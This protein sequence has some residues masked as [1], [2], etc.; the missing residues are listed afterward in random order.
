MYLSLRNLI[1]TELYRFWMYESLDGSYLNPRLIE[2]IEEFVKNALQHDEGHFS[3][4]LRCPCT[5]CKN[6]R[7]QTVDVLKYHLVSRGLRKGYYV[8]MYHDESWGTVPQVEVVGPSN[9]FQPMNNY[10]DMLVDAFPLEYYEEIKTANEYTY[11]E[12]PPSESKYYFDM[13][14]ASQSPLYNGCKL[15]LLVVASCLLT[16]KCKYNLGCISL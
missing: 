12:G 4:C 16:L 14:N 8:W 5:K 7:F 10:E 15:S 6:G 11:D 2:G 13:L 9:V 3:E 1:D